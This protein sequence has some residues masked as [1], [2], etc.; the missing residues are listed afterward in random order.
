MTIEAN[1]SGKA[2]LEAR[3][4]IY[5]VVELVRFHLT[6]YI[7]VTDEGSVESRASSCDAEHDVLCAD[8]EL[9]SK[10]SGY[11]FSP[12]KYSNIVLSDLG[13]HFFFICYI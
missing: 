8:D 10:P 1:C 11:Q 2:T 9:S 13:L 3:F 5:A 7:R 12:M 6:S 4:T